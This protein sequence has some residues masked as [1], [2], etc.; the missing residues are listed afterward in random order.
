M[1]VTLCCSSLFSSSSSIIRCAN[2]QLSASLTAR[3][4]ESNGKMSLSLKNF[5]LRAFQIYHAIHGNALSTSELTPLSFT[6]NN[7]KSMF[8]Y[9][10][11]HGNNPEEDGID[12]SAQHWRAGGHSKSM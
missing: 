6:C 7:K 8:E 11:L 1:F 2:V 3:L 5:S 4:R 12:D 10:E 9:N